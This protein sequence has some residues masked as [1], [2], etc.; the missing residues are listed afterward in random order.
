MNL[1]DFLKKNVENHGDKIAVIDNEK[2]ITFIELYEKVEKFSNNI[3]ILNQEEIISLISENSIS[4]IIAYLGIINSGKIVHLISPEISEINLFNQLK[5]SKSKN[6]ICNQLMKKK[7]L[8]F[9]SIKTTI[10]DI[11]EILLKHNNKEIESSLNKFAYLIYTSGTTAEPKGVTVSHSMIEF[12][13]KNIVKVLGYSNSDTDLLPLPLNH[14][15]GLGCIHTSLYVGSTLVL[16]KNASNLEEILESLKKYKIT[17][18][19][20][21][22]A[23]LTKILNFENKK[24][25]DYFSEIRLIITNSTAIPKKTVIQFKEILKKGN[26]ATYYGLTEASR[27][28]FMVFDKN[29]QREE[30]VGKCSPNVEIKIVNKEENNLKLGDIF[31]KGENV[32]KKYWNNVEADK[33][34]FENWLKTGDTGY[35]DNEGYLFLKGRSDEIIN[36]G[37]EKVMPIE[38]E[39]TIKNIPGVEDAVAFGIEH[40]IFGQTIKLNIIKS[41]NSDI[42]KAQIL[43]YCIKNLERF[44][45]PSKIDFVE[46]IPKT[47][48]G[49]VKRF[50]LK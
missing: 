17:T 46:K 11:E 39:Q 48:Y 16:L 27:S 49:K 32:I 10:F 50:M 38:I 14:S 34:I 8:N 5:S 24:L 30:S 6:I 25:E 47:D 33:N 4:F 40:E 28:T 19:A 21:I 37:G 23:T 43:S 15:F 12:T 22:P 31:I 41:K 29:N 20:A 1:I 2:E 7:I 3:K 42:D 35:F 9:N 26:L 44:K 36:V 18:L 45:I 13:T